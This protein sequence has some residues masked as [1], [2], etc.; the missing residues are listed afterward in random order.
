M[1][2]K[3]LILFM[4]ALTSSLVISD[5]SNGLL[6]IGL[7]KR[8]LDLNSR[9]A[10]RILRAK[11]TKVHQKKLGDSD[12]DIVA[13]KNF[14][15]AQYY[16]EIRIGTPP[17]TFTVVFDTGSSNLWV[18]SSKCYFSIACYLHPRYKASKSCTYKKNGAHCAITYGS[19]SISGFFSEDD[20]KVGD[21]VVKDQS[22]IEATQEGS[23]SF[24]LA[25]FD[26]ILGLG[27]QEIS[28]GNAVPVWY[29]MVAQ[30]L[31]SEEIFS[32]WLNRDAKAKDGG[33]IVFGGVD[34]K[35]YKGCHTYVPITEKGYWQFEMGDI[36]IGNHSTGFCKGGCSAIA[37]SGTSLLAGPSAIVTEINYAIGA[38]GIVSTECRDVASQH[39]DMIWELLVTG[40]KPNQVCSSL[41][42]CLA[43]GDHTGIETVVEKENRKKQ[44]AGDDTR[45]AACE[46][47]VAWIRKEHTL[48]KTKE[49]LLSYVNHLCESLQSPISFV[50]CKKI[51]SMPDVS[52]TIG[53]KSFVLTPEQYILK[54]GEGSSTICLSGF[55][56]FDLPPPRGPLWILGDVFMG[57]YHTVFDYG[58][59]RIGF[60][61]AA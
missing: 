61:E 15:D 3:L 16:G 10:A 40:I 25:Q 12:G 56:G 21:L 46:L 37:D 11:V 17:Q 51:S 39:G 20:V 27:F 22:F 18:P 32:F 43:N 30:G 31:V 53:D 44:T 41:G 7:K 8:Q 49:Q 5:S 4:F 55:M 26:G 14:L 13:L 6:R 52:F 1:M 9:I 59:L 45:C 42:L 34:P 23:L 48:N 33:E 54:I 19:G 29:N 36:L 2:L 50:D 35:H 58:N 28:V 47:A 24:I 38:K 57:V 60:A